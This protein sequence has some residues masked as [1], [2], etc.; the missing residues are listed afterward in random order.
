MRCASSAA[1]VDRRHDG[2]IPWGAWS[3]RVLRDPLFVFLLVGLAVFAL[4]ELLRGDDSRTVVVTAAHQDRLV[5]LW[6]AQTGRSP[7]PSELAALIEDHVREEILV[8]EAKRLRL[9]DGDTVIRRRLA[10]KLSFLSEDMATLE[11]PEEAALRA[12]FEKHRRRYERPAVLSFSHIYFSPDKREDAA[13]D[14]RR[15]L[16]EMDPEAWRSTG[17]P[18]MLGRTYAHSS[19][20]RVRR[21]F[22][23]GFAAELDELEEAPHWR[24]PLQSGHG[25]HLLRVDAKSPALGADFAA[26]AQRVAM[27]FDTERR[28]A[29]NRAHFEELRAQY[30]VELP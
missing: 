8:R 28:A 25:F 19:L 2:G 16:A 6:Q 24:G 22:G 23:D 17:D 13:A 21:D 15:A 11:E 27:D 3:R 1:P 9:D 14:A 5:E 20:A 18:F 12:Y 26:V 4:D 30:R 29:A 10:Q 7:S